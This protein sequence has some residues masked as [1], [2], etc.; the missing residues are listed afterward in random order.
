M[1]FIRT[2]ELIFVPVHTDPGN[3]STAVLCALQHPASP[4]LSACLMLLLD[5][6][7]D[8][9]DF[10]HCWFLLNQDFNIFHASFSVRSFHFCFTR[11]WLLIGTVR[12]PTR[13]TVHHPHSAMSDFFFYLTQQVSSCQVHLNR[14]FT[15][16]FLFLCR[17]SFKF[18]CNIVSSVYT[19]WHNNRLLHVWQRRWFALWKCLDGC[20]TAKYALEIEIEK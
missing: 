4:P 11:F 8:W 19:I 12:L 14:S 10:K 15:L 20:L 13:R 16:D 5:V 18:F 17:V 1:S 6:I 3:G 2:M 9:C 7:L